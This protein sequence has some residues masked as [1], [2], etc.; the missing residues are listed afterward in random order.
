MTSFGSGDCARESVKHVF[1]RLHMYARIDTDMHT[2]GHRAKPCTNR[3]RLVRFRTLGSSSWCFLSACCPIL[4]V[5]RANSRSLTCS[6]LFILNLPHTNF[7]R[8]HPFIQPLSMITN[9]SRF[10]KC[11]NIS[12]LAAVHSGTQK[13]HW[14]M[15]QS[16]F[17]RRL[18]GRSTWANREVGCVKDQQHV[19]TFLPR[20]IVQR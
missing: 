7:G 5:V 11:T 20:R 6:T 2:P 15:P 18:L 12:V 3:H 17:R 19:S 8:A 10:S 13:W 16:V 9:R 4:V 14:S 1:M